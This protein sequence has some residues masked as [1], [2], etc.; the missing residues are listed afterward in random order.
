VSEHQW[1]ELVD[2]IFSVRVLDA[3]MGSGH[4]LVEAVDFITDRMLHFLKGFGW[5]PV[6]AHIE[7]V[8]TQILEEMDRQGVTI[9][10]GRLTDVNLVK[11]HVLK[12]CIFGVDLN[13]MAVELAK[14][15]L[16]L[17]CF[18]LGAPLSFLDHHL[19]CGNSLLGTTA[20]EVEDA[21]R[22]GGHLPTMPT[23]LGHGQ[24]SPRWLPIR[25]LPRTPATPSG[26]FATGP[27]GRTRRNRGRATSASWLPPVRWVDA[28]DPPRVLS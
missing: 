15:S 18:T 25:V 1:H 9:D 21:L 8:R 19:R 28:P 7:Y 14:V 22:M 2:E 12:R 5:N 27:E 11:R 23:H 13:P 6:Y 17:D 20:A 24:C 26:E 10:P 4:F 16:W 3:A